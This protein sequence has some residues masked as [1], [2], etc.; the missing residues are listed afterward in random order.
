MVMMMMMM[1][2]VHV[3][4]MKC[5]ERSGWRG[6]EDDGGVEDSLKLLG[7]REKKVVKRKIRW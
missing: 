2:S 5:I 4:M 7:L 3:Y 6:D 1:M